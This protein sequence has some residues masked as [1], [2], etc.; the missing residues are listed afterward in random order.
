MTSFGE[1][2]RDH[3]MSA[4]L[5]MGDV[6]RAWKCSTAYVSKM[7]SGGASAATDSNIILACRL[8]GIPP[9][10][11]LAAKAA[12]RGKVEMALSEF[13]TVREIQLEL[14]KHSALGSDER[15]ILTAIRSINRDIS[16]PS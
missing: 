10:T 16:R 1:Q 2:F 11:L 8:F 5:S 9:D 3:R 12:Q 14:A 6:A 13:A 7:E 4:G 15:T